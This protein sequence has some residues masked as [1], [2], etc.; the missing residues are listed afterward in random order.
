VMSPNY[1]RTP[2][3]RKEFWTAF[4][5]YRIPMSALLPDGT[6]VN[7]RSWKWIL[8]FVRYRGT[9]GPV[10]SALDA[11]TM[12]LL[13]LSQAQSPVQGSGC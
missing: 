3:T 10:S 1:L 4:R 8:W 11:Q 7:V 2:W 12:A 9:R 5:C 13:T 6:F